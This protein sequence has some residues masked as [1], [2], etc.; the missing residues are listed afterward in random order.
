VDFYESIALSC[1]VFYY[2]LAQRLGPD[3]LAQVARAFGLGQRTGIDLP[4]ERSGLVPD[5]RWKREQLKQPWF[6]G[7]TLNYGIGQG[8]LAITPLQGAVMTMGLA[9]RGIMYRPHLVKNPQ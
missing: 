6:G 2:Q 5:T 3:N 8:Y 7:E 4:H 9:N 1:D